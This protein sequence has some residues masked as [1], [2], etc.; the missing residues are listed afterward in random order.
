M[1][2]LYKE[3]FSRI[4]SSYIIRKKKMI[5]HLNQNGY[6]YIGMGMIIIILIFYLLKKL[7]LNRFLSKFL[8]MLE[9]NTSNFLIYLFLK[10]LTINRLD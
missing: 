7:L 3:H 9:I 10:I 4:Y 8:W 5:N 6:S 1:K 2:N